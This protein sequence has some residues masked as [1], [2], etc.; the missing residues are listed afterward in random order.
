V[1]DLTVAECLVGP[2]MTNNA[3]LETTHRTFFADPMTEVLLPKKTS[4]EL[5]ARIRADLSFELVDALHLA[6]A[7]DHHCDLFLTNDG[8]LTTYTGVPVER[9]R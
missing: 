1:S 7:T 5:A 3:K 4:F 2:F 6:I 8:K 9:L